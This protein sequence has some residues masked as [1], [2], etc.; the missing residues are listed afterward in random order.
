MLLVF[1]PPGMGKIFDLAI[2]FK[3]QSPFVGQLV[4]QPP[5]DFELETIDL[6]VIADLTHKEGVDRDRVAPSHEF[7][8]RTE[9]DLIR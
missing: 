3:A 1:E 8:K 2:G 5:E 6:H 7:R 9:Q 4:F